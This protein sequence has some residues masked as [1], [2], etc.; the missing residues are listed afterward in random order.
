MIEIDLSTVG[1][2]IAW[3]GAYF[4]IY[5]YYFFKFMGK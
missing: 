4:G 2:V 3:G 5:N 1:Q